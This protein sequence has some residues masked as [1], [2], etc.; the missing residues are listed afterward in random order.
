MEEEAVEVEEAL[1]RRRHLELFV[2]ATGSLVLW[3]LGDSHC[4]THRQKDY[5]EVEDVKEFMR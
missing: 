5:G 4:W 2:G 3:E 1:R